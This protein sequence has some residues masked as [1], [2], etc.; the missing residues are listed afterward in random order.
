MIDNEMISYA[1]RLSLKKN[2]WHLWDSTTFNSEGLPVAACRS[3]L[4]LFP[5]SPTS[6]DF[7]FDFDAFLE[8]PECKRCVKIWES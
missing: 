5:K 2:S 4:A 7:D 3:N 8:K 6:M 1:W